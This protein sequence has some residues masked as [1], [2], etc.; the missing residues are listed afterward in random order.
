MNWKMYLLIHIKTGFKKNEGQEDDI[1][2]M[3]EKLIAVLMLIL[4]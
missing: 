4:G 2:I 1:N 3:V